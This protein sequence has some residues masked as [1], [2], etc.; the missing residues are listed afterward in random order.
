MWLDIYSQVIWT[1]ANWAVGQAL[2]RVIAFLSRLL[3]QD[4]AYM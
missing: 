2:D 4:T 1:P 3:Q